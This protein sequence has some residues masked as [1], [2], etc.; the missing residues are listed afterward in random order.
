MKELMGI[1]KLRQQ[2]SSDFIY[3]FVHIQIVC[4]VFILSS[5]YLWVAEA[6]KN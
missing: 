6:S 1:L 2:H 4:V 5:F 3:D